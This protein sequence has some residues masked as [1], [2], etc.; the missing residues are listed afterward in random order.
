MKFIEIE[1]HLINLSH[2]V[3]I[4]FGREDF[5]DYPFLIVFESIKD[6]WTLY[7]KNIERQHEDYT[8]IFKFL[9]DYLNEPNIP[10]L[11]RYND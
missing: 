2:V 11:K 10:Q 6:A 5:E 9:S 1:N 8:I 4:H 3:N 7:Y